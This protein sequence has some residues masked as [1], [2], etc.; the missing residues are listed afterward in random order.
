LSI[1]ARIS[2]HNME[3]SAALE[4]DVRERI[5]KLARYYDR[6]EA[7]EVTI[8]APHHHHH[9]GHHYRVLIKLLVP[10]ETLVV[11]QHDGDKPAHED[12]Y[13]AI[14]DAFRAMR[15]RLQDYAQIQRQ[16]VKRHSM[17]TPEDTA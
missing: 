1:S 17:T 9:K 6:I 12:C 2:F 16:D 8:E 5:D 15:R 13:V 11:N 10:G 14:H 7:C 4:A 3:G